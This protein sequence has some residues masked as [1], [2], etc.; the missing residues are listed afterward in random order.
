MKHILLFSQ[1]V[2]LFCVLLRASLIL[3]D[4]KVVRNLNEADV[5][6][7]LSHF[8]QFHR[9]EAKVM[10]IKGSMGPS[11]EAFMDYCDCRLNG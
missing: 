2:R 5:K 4:L 10:P 3:S 7:I 8:N 1:W 11:G 6:C 9:S